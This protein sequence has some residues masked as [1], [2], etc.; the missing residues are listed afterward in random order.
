[1]ISS[2]DASSASSVAATASSAASSAGAAGSCD[3]PAPPSPP[4]LFLHSRQAPVSRTPAA[5]LMPSL[6]TSSHSPCDEGRPACST[7]TKVTHMASEAERKKVALRRLGDA[8]LS[9]PHTRR[10]DHA[11]MLGSYLRVSGD[12]ARGL[13]A[14]PYPTLCV[15]R[16]FYL[17]PYLSF[18]AFLGAAAT[19]SIAGCCCLPPAPG[20]GECQRG[21]GAGRAPPPPWQGPGRGAARSSPV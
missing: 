2:A 21:C 15:E 19:G 17:S 13:P 8:T 6:R 14:P 7:G 12:L 20:P 3:G 11:W 10:V 4:F 16:E 9:A 18:L 1:M 5:P